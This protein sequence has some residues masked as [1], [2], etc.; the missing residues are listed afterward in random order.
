MKKLLSPRPFHSLRV[1]SKTPITTL[2]PLNERQVTGARL[3]AF[4]H[5]EFSRRNYGRLSLGLKPSGDIHMGTVATV[6]NGM[7]YLYDNKDATLKIDVMDLDYDTQRG[8]NFASFMRMPDPNGCHEL[9]KFHTL[10][11]LGALVDK[12]SRVIGIDSRRIEIGLYSQNFACEGFSEL[13]MSLIRERSRAR[14]VKRALFD[15]KSKIHLMPFTPICPECGHSSS[16][17][18]R[19]DHKSDTLSSTCNN[20]EC[21]NF[22]QVFSVAVADVTS[23]NVHYLIDPVRD[24]FE[25]PGCVRSDVH[26]FGGDYLITHG[27]KRK[28]KVQRSADVMTAVTN[29]LPD[30]YVGPMLTL[31]SRKMSKSMGAEI[32]DEHVADKVYSKLAQI[33]RDSVE[34]ILEVWNVIR[35]L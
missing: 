3:V 19:Y 29:E 24:V 18:G 8:N 22:E 9:M 10:E 30:F 34:P 1:G 2:T 31:N 33:L 11:K 7:L 15:G 5:K 16:K 28:T 23:Y 17:N 32:A 12:L 13:M 20:D 6:L 21:S 4:D 25:S 26:I 35:V 14:I 27:I